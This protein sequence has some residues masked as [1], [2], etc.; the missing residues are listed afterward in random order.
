M[1][2]RYEPAGNMRG[3]FE[4][5]LL[6][7]SSSETPQVESSQPCS[8]HHAEGRE[9]N[10]ANVEVDDEGKASQKFQFGESPTL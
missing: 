7:T 9:Q 6:P 1:C 8:D 2:A 4:E 10:K 5:N 3:S